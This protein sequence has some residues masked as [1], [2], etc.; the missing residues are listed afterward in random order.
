[1]TVSPQILLAMTSRQTSRCLLSLLFVLS[2][3]MAVIGDEM[4]DHEFIAIGN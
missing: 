3:D 1:M 4:D 2:L